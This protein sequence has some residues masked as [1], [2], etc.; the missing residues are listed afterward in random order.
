MTYRADPVYGNSGRSVIWG[1]LLN[2]ASRTIGTSRFQIS[3]ASL[4]A[5][6]PD[7][8]SQRGWYDD[9]WVVVYEGRNWNSSVDDYDIYLTRV[10]SGGQVLSSRLVGP[11]GG[12]DKVRPVVEGW[13]GRYLVAMLADPLPEYGG[14][15]W[16]RNVWTERFDW[17]SRNTAPTRYGPRQLVANANQDVSNMR[18]AFDGLSFSHWCLVYQ[19]DSLQAPRCHVKRLGSGGGVTEAALLDGG[20]YGRYHPSV[21]WNA[22]AREFPVVYCSS[23]ASQPVY[24]Q[25]LQYPGSAVNVVYG[26]ACGNTPTSV[27]ADR[28]LAGSEFFTMRFAGRPAGTSTVLLL[29]LGS[30]AMPLDHLGMTGCVLRISPLT[31]L[32]LFAVPTTTTASGAQFQLALPDTPAFRSDL[33]AQWVWVQPGLNAAGLGATAGLRMQVR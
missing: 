13:D 30:A 7:V 4:D 32:F 10:T 15:R 29:S 31:G 1:V 18:L 12:G 21:A 19:A 11:D 16:A 20:A 25:R 2:A 22:R 9:T 3:P 6:A 26:A 23:E 24:G 17:S 33:F 5:E 8:N 28:P 14:M 27:T